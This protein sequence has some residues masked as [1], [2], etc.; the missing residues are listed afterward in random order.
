MIKRIRFIIILLIAQL[1]FIGLYINKQSQWVKIMYNQQ[2]LEKTYATLI[3]KKQNLTNELS[4]LH[5]KNTLKSY[6]ASKGLVPLI[7]SQTKKIVL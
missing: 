5:N 4:S 7:L 1:I 2:I 3:I 6:S